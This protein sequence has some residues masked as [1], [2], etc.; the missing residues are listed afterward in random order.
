[1]NQ[2]KCG[3][4]RGPHARHVYV[5]QKRPRMQVQE[6]RT[7]AGTKTERPRDLQSVSNMKSIRILPHFR[8]FHIFLRNFDCYSEV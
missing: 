5:G 7:R 2:A 1:M 4:D 8:V 6:V 3:E